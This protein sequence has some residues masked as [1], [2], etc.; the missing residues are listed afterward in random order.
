[1]MQLNSSF[2]EKDKVH[3]GLMSVHE[4]QQQALSVWF[5]YGQ[6]KFPVTVKV[7][8]KCVRPTLAVF[9][10]YLMKAM[11]GSLGNASLSCLHALRS[12][13]LLYCCLLEPA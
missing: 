5:G 2:E 10:L 7:S 8:P 12:V 13:H 1:M 9:L 11:F 6:G 3:D 4:E